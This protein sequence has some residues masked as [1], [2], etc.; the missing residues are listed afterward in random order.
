MNIEQLREQRS[1]GFRRLRFE[2]ELEHH[3]REIRN[4][5]IRERARPV[6]AAALLLFLVYAVLD[7]LMLPPSIAR[8][9]MS[10]RLLITCPVI[11]AVWWL[12]WRNISA[13]TFVRLYGIAYLIG[14]LSV[15]VIIGIARVADHPLPYEGILLMLMFGYFVMGIPFR[16]VSILSI[17]VI[18]SYLAVEAATGMSTTQASGQWFLYCHCEYYRYGGLLAQRASTACTLS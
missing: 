1:S 18:A 11:A 17:I 10:V 14:G 8:E 7:A 15:V 12:S 6:S 16:T 9:T 4:Q 5:G 3:Y 13:N 2:P